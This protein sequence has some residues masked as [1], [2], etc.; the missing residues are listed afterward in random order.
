MMTIISDDYCCGVKPKEKVRKIYYLKYQETCGNRS[1]VISRDYI[2]DTRIC[3]EYSVIKQKAIG[4]VY[5]QGS[6]YCDAKGLSQLRSCL[7][8]AILNPAQR[9]GKN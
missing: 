2:I 1:Y 6:P 3:W 4:F 7:H 8:D 9:I 5:L